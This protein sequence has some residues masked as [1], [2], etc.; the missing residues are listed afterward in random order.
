ME[1]EQRISSVGYGVGYSWI[2]LIQGSPAQKS[3]AIMH[4]AS[5]LKG[6][7]FQQ[8]TS[9]QESLAHLRGGS[10]FEGGAYWRIYDISHYSISS[11]N[12]FASLTK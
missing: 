7:H 5:V 2:A 8:G 12:S 10:L 1:N 9:V 4:F 3:D 6:V 11:F